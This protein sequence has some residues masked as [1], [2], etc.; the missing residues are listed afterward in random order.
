M[1]RGIKNFK[2]PATIMALKWVQPNR[3][4]STGDGGRVRSCR[5]FISK[6]ASDE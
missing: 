2:I 3:A 5:F 1:M 6:S 4:F